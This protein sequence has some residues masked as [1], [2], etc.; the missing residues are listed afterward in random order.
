M[1]DSDN[2]SPENEPRAPVPLPV[3]DAERLRASLDQMYDIFKDMAMTADQVSL[4]RCPYKNMHN[5]C[6]AQFGCRN[7]RRTGVAGELPICAGDDK[8]NY[9]S[10]WET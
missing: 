10:A 5:R 7:Q 8:L 6:T 4:H 3:V 9:R 2:R 1:S